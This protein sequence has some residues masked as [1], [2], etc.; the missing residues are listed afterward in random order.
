[1]RKC[2]YATSRGGLEGPDRGRP[3]PALGHNRHM[4]LSDRPW[5][6]TNAHGTENL[7]GGWDHQARPDDLA[8]RLTRLAAG[9]PSADPAGDADGDDLDTEDVGPEDLGPESLDPDD[10]DPDDEVPENLVPDDVGSDDPEKGDAAG[11]IRAGRR[12]AMP[13]WG[14]LGEPA[15]SPYRPWFGAD[16]VTDPWFAADLTE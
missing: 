5:A 6:E 3:G 16:G 2:T 12:E 13:A 7:N 10:L 9:H 1:M 14:E 4:R 8:S 15:R 11:D